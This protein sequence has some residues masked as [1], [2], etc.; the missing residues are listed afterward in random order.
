MLD[1]PRKVQPKSGSTPTH[2][3]ISIK[4]QGGDAARGQEWA[5]AAS[6]PLCGKVP[7]LVG[8]A[9][10]GPD[11]EEGAVGRAG[12]GGVEALRGLWVVEFVEPGLLP[13]LG[14]GAVAV[15][16]LHL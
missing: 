11:L 1:T 14:A 13:D 9:A 3:L 4:V 12:A 10:A 6:F 7:L 2:R 15:P 8:A 16:D 5:R